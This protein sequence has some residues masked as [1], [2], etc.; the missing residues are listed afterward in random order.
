[1]LLLVNFKQSTSL[2]PVLN[3]LL[4][5]SYCLRWQELL[6]HKLE[7]LEFLL[8]IV[9]LVFNWS[10]IECEVSLEHSKPLAAFR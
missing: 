5:F 9:D 6:L 1:M 8:L 4:D 10:S 7:I 3:E 2:F